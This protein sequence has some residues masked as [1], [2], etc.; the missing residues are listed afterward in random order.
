MSA[1]RQSF[2]FVAL[3]CAACSTVPDR[4]AVEKSV[5]SVAQRFVHGIETYDA[6]AAAREFDAAAVVFM[7]G[8]APR[9]SGIEAIRADLH[10]QFDE[11]RAAGRT[12][13]ITPRRPNLQVFGDTA[14]LTFE[15]GGEAPGS[16]GA[17]GVLSRRTLVMHRFADAWRIVHLHGSNFQVTQQPQ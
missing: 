12:R 17:T 2:V 6:E 3:L 13:V 11:G 15:L 14:I 4:A 8:S 10:A 7:P 1:I 16:P 5:L 9:L